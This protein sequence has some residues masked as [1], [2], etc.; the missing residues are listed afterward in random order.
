VTIT[1][2]GRLR[3]RDLAPAMKASLQHAFRNWHREAST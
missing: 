3:E 2:S 1:A